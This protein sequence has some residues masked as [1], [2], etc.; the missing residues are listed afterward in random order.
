MT[1]SGSW[2]LLPSQRWM[3]VLVPRVPENGA[4]L[5]HPSVF[6]NQTDRLLAVCDEPGSVVVN[7]FHYHENFALLLRPNR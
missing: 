7:S 2:S 6:G 5:R 3:H 4:E 1:Q